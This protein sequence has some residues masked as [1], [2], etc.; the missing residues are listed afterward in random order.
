VAISKNEIA[1][2]IPNGKSHLVILGTMG[3]ICARIVNEK[4]KI[5]PARFAYTYKTEKTFC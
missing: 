5:R 4:K 2:F 3:S 1:P